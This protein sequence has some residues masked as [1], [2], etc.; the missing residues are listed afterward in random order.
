MVDG[1]LNRPPYEQSPAARA[2]FDHARALAAEIGFDLVG[3]ATGGGS[4]G[5]FTAPTVPTLDGLGVDG[6][7][8]HTLTEHLY[9]SSIR[10]HTDLLARLMATLT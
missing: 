1:R 3:V 9:I 6:H 5:N 2:L 8:A 10:P 4:D 7:G